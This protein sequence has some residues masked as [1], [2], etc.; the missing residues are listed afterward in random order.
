[1]KYRKKCLALVLCLVLCV[2]FPLQVSAVSGTT[3]GLIRE[4]ILDYGYYPEIAGDRV[5]A[6]LEEL[7]ARDPENGELWRKIMEGWDQ[8]AND[9]ELNYDLLPMEL[10]DS[11]KLCIVVL[12]YQLN[13]DGTIQPE[14]EGRLFTALSCAVWYPSAY[15]LCTGG[16]TAAGNRKITEASQM[17]EWLVYHGIEADR[18]LVEDQSYT[19]GMNAMLSY[20]LIREKC[21]EVET[22]AIVS[23]DYHIP[24]ATA[25]FQAQFLLAEKK[26]GLPP[27][28]LVSNAAYEAI[29]HEEY[30]FFFQAAGILELAG[31][32]ETA[33]DVYHCVLNPPKP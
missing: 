33:M 2:S 15:V 27:L 19:T 32:W 7:T 17:A 28:T 1:M 11:D 30:P 12:G 4:M 10:E 3:Y 23:S 25:L 9:L 18:I 26:D 21:P 16:G 29:E 20:D 13:P 5:E 22:V 14:L 24:W 31:Y 6:I 8:A